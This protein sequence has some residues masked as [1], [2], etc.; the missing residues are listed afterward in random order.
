[1][2]RT[3]SVIADGTS[4]QRT[5]DN[6]RLWDFWRGAI[7][8][9]TI[10]LLSYHRI[11]TLSKPRLHQTLIASRAAGEGH[12]KKARKG[13]RLIFLIGVYKAFE[14]VTWGYGL[15][16]LKGVPSRSRSHAMGSGM[17]ARSKEARL[18]F[19]PAS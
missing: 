2:T 11:I 19:L 16:S 4:A 18:R 7:K 15:K 3:L 9:T 1:M 6:A 14:P 10:G 13:H 5:L 8:N 17:M 12:G